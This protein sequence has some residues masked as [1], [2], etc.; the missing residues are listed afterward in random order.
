[1]KTKVEIE[2]NS[3][4]ITVINDGQVMYPVLSSELDGWTRK[5]GSITSENYDEFCAA[6]DCIGE[7]C[8]GTPGNES[9]VDLCASLIA[10]GCD[11]CGF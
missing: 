11:V 8:V 3:D 7:K 1:M 6:V 2:N 4:I 9:M 10:D 5:H